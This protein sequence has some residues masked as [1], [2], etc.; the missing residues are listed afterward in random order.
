MRLCTS[1]RFSACLGVSSCV[2]L[3]EHH[4]P[5]SAGTCVSLCMFVS[6]CAHK[7][8]CEEITA[9]YIWVAGG[10]S[11]SNSPTLTLVSEHVLQ[12]PEWW[13]ACFHGVATKGSWDTASSFWAQFHGKFVWQNLEYTETLH[14]NTNVPDI[15]GRQETGQQPM[16]AIA[17]QGMCGQRFFW[18]PLE[19]GFLDLHTLAVSTSQSF[20]WK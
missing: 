10:W 16:V 5:E 2:C 1:A 8:T 11:Q 18:W 12:E 15:T 19:H 20:A 14:S 6:V 3:Y 17:P 13:K 9:N 4:M 7:C